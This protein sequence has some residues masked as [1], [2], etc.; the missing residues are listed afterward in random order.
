MLKACM[1]DGFGWFPEARYRRSWLL[2]DDVDYIFPNVVSGTMIPQWVRNSRE[3]FVIEPEIDE[4]DVWELA[5]AAIKT[6]KDPSYRS[7]L[8]RAIPKTDLEYAVKVVRQDTDLIRLYSS[9]DPDDPVFAISYLAEKLVHYSECEGSI[10]IVGQ[11]YAIALLTNIVRRRIETETATL[12]DDALLTGRQA[13][14]LHAFAAGLSLRF[15][16]DEDLL[17]SD[18]DILLNFKRKNQELLD[19]H[20]THLLDVSQ[21]FDGLPQDSNF[22]DQLAQ[23]RSEAEATR[24]Q[25]DE[26]ACEAWIEAGLK[27][28]KQA[29]VAG[30]GG[31]ITALGVIGA[32][33]T[34]EILSKA[35]PAAIA[36]AGIAAATSIGALVK[37][38]KARRTQLSYLL[39]AEKYLARLSS[40]PK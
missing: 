7:Q 31:L 19:L 16:T 20:H 37:A 34:M 26:H 21:Q 25:M 33:P 10:P 23:L 35:A 27:V 15:L 36:G 24:R 32:T 38:K 11:D 22:F 30:T 28:A 18:I 29:L 39:N 2:F 8:L 13:V 40:V 9:T 4:S 12:G 17:S 14:S 1:I 6:S 5:V 3:C